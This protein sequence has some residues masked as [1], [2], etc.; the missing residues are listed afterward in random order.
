MLLLLANVLFLLGAI[1]AV[2]FALPKRIVRGENMVGVHLITGTMALLQGAGLLA[3]MAAGSFAALD[4]R[5]FVVLA[6]LPGYLLAMTALPILSVGKGRG[7]V[8]MTVA[9][10]LV[11]GGGIVAVNAAAALPHTLALAGGVVVG[12]GAV[13]GYLGVLCLWLEQVR[14]RARARAHEAVRQDDFETRQSA[15][16]RGEYAKLPAE[17]ELWQLLQ[18]VRSL[19]KD[20][21][22]DAQAR[23]AARPEL[24]KELTAMLESKSSDLAL[25]YLMHPAP[26]PYAALAPAVRGVLDRELPHWEAVLGRGEPGAWRGNVMKLLEVAVQVHFGGGDVA[27]PLRRWRAMLAKHSPFA[28]TV[29]ELDRAMQTKPRAQVAS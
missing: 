22:D 2:L 7:P 8:L 15:F 5:W 13:G 20:V 19:A 6:L 17:P 14:N 27:E 1:P 25:D 11:A 3:A 18:F 23:V 12:A 10:V 29:R 21:R 24:V 4:V 28:Q 9:T 16:Q 26:L